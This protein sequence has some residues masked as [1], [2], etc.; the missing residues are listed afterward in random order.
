MLQR[1]KLDFLDIITDGATHHP[2]VLI[3]ARHKLPVICQKPM[4]ESLSDAA[5]VMLHM[6][7]G[8]TVTVQVA[9]AGNYLEHDLFTQTLIFV[10]GDQ[11]SAEF[12]RHF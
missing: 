1:E 8:A 2:Y 6:A 10:E 11:G 4:A 12:D 5:T 3:A 7:S 9:F